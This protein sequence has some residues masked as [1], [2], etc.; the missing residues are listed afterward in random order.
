MTTVI[1]MERVDLGV[2]NRKFH[3]DVVIRIM[4]M[5]RMLMEGR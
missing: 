1:G 2:V 5:S 4:L 3:W